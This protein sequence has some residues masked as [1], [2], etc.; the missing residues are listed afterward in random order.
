MDVGGFV[1]SGVAAVQAKHP[2]SGVRTGRPTVDDQ[3]ANA[4]PLVGDDDDV[5]KSLVGPAFEDV[6]GEEAITLPLIAHVA[7]KG[8][9]MPVIPYGGKGE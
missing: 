4:Q 2:Q 5:A 9:S 7:A 6:G 3:D 8:A 1:G